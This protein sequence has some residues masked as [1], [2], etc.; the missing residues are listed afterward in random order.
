MVLGEEL[1]IYSQPSGEKG[2][3]QLVF[4]RSRFQLAVYFAIA[5]TFCQVYRFLVSAVDSADLR[6]H[7]ISHCIDCGWV[8]RDGDNDV[9]AHDF[10]AFESRDWR[11]E[12]QW[13]EQTGL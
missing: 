7:F 12:D 11:W 9:R 3:V 10:T 2:V 8:G 13:K 4:Q 5:S 6:V 1:I